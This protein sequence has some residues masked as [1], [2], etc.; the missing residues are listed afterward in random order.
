MWLA[1]SLFQI[2]VLT[3]HPRPAYWE[4]GGTPTYME[5]SKQRTY[6]Q[7]PP[8]PKEIVHCKIFGME[9][10]SKEVREMVGIINCINGV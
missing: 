9:G 10:C 8:P 5:A 1:Y 3:L 6:R 4:K 7:T 2:N